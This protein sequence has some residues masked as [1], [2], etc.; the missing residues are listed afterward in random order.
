MVADEVAVDTRRARTD[1]AWRWSSDG[2]GAFTIAPLSAL[3]RAEARKPRVPTSQRGLE[4]IRSRLEA[5]AQRREPSGAL[6]VPIDLVEK[7]GAEKQ[8]ISEGQALSTRPKSDIT[9]SNTSIYRTLAADSTTRP[10]HPLARGRPP[11]I[12]CSPSCRVAAVRSL[13]IPSAKVTTSYVRHV[14]I[15]D[16]ADILPGW[17]R[18]VRLVVDTADLPLDVSRKIIQGA[19][20]SPPSARA[21]PIGSCRSWQARRN[22]AGEVRRG[23]GNFGAVLKEGLYEDPD[24]ATACST[25]PASSARRDLRGPTLEGYVAGLH[26]SQTAIYYLLGDEV[27][28]LAASPQ[29][30]GFPA[31]GVEVRFCPIPSTPSGSRPPS[32][33]MASLQVGDPGRDRHR[34][35]RTRRGRERAGRGDDEVGHPRCSV[36]S[37]RR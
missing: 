27:K 11:R 10:D 18:F 3:T 5:G 32:V 20:F 19:R 24:V 37:R 25:S 26:P 15:T 7:S 2:K 31:R 4:G 8:R 12:P 34:V 35:D 9:P 36:S 33:S 21:S 16:D 28:R 22:Q 1:G 6:A 17:L 29:L 23:L 14:L 13:S 30:E